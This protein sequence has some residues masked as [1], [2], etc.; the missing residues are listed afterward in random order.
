M[1]C[2]LRWGLVNLLF[3]LLGVNTLVFMVVWFSIGL[4]VNVL[5]CVVRLLCCTSLFVT[6]VIVL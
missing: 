5:F 6:L 3:V 2:C 1:I 4:F